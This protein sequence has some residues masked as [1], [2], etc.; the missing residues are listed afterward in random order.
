MTNSTRRQTRTPDDRSAGVDPRAG[1][2]GVDPRAG[3]GQPDGIDPQEVLDAV[4]AMIGYWDAALRNRFANE[5]YVDFFGRVPEEFRG[6]HMSELL[7][8]ELYE[9]NRPYA[10]RALAGEPQ[11]FDRTIIDP[12]GAPRHTQASYIPHVVDGEVRGFFALVTDITARRVAEQAHAAA[13]SRFRLAFSGSPVGMGMM[14]SHAR[15]IQVNRALSRML[16]Y[17][18]QELEGRVFTDLVSP[19][20]R[21]VERRRIADL[22]AGR[23]A[24]A[25]AERRLIAGD[26]SEIWVIVSLALGR[27][28][29]GDEPLAIGHVQ[30]ISARRRAEDEL[31]RSRARLAEAELIAQ[32]GSWEW[33][34]AGDR[35]SWSDGLFAIL[36]LTPE[37]FDPTFAASE[38][39]V[40][41]EDRQLVRQA[42]ELSIAE[43]SPFRIEYRAVRPDGRVRT[44]RSVGEVVVDEAGE[45]TRL[46]GISQDITDEKLAREALQT[47]SADLE[48]R[49]IELQR[50]AL[51]TPGEPTPVGS[52]PLSARQ[53]EI[54]RLVA[55]GLTSGEIAQRLFVTEG[56][57]KWHVKQILAK[58][59]SSTRAEAVARILGGQS[60]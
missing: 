60:Y 59:G 27:S 24:P 36:G 45:P 16:D 29:G 7:G 37:Q 50:L 11:L 10:E 30:D 43:R 47:T 13:E 23:T 38:E 42:L 31:R 56:T 32:M 52:A 8:P 25:S 46:V 54:L 15:L 12:A 18:P 34:I 9:L 40:Y 35:I 49:A 39:R 48:R 58:T 51:R 28:D 57:V 5:A 33:D 17:S 6:R 3:V 2:D 41:P 26:G 55:A 19:D 4:P 53:L 14:D 20:L 21:E 44:L 1:I 22:F